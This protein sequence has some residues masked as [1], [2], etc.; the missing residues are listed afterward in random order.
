MAL[1]EDAC[2]VLLEHARP[3]IVKTVVDYD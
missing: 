1:E 2:P 3:I